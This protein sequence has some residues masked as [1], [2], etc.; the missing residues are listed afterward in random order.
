MKFG[1]NTLYAVLCV[2]YAFFIAQATAADIFRDTEGNVWRNEHPHGI[3][4]H[5]NVLR[6]DT[7]P[8]LQPYGKCI[9]YCYETAR[10]TVLREGNWAGEKCPVA[11][12]EAPNYFETPTEA[13]RTLFAMEAQDCERA[14]SET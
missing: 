2:V 14:A 12:Q 7:P 6:D 9:E 1:T 8:V 11:C 4:S 3:G 5:I 10:Y 13:W